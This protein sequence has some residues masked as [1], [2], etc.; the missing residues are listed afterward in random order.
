MKKIK[1]ILLIT[2]VLLGFLSTPSMIFA[3]G[4]ASSGAGCN[5]VAS[6]KI[7][8]VFSYMSCILNIAVVPL[9]FS[10]ALA[11]FVFGVVQYVLNESDEGKREK[12]KQFMVWG[13][14]AL[15]VM[16]SVWGLV[17]M[18]GSTFNIDTRIVPSVTPN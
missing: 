3:Q 15:T 16:V 12:G 6:P 9:I 2:F 1:N 18:L 10:L 5:L 14:I 17:N 8:D 11:S 7:Q 13:I 4:N